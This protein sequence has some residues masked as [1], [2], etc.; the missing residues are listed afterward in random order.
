[1]THE[2]MKAR[3]GIDKANCGTCCHLGSEDDGNYPEFAISWP[4]CHKYEQIANLKGFPFKGEAKCWE[5]EFWASKFADDIKTGEHDEIM[6]AIDRFVAARDAV[7]V[8]SGTA[9]AGGE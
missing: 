4:V 5:P 7:C 9:K 3:L 2:D 8:D 6:A 1:M